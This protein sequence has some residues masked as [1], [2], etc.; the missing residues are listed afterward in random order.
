MVKP[1]I[2]LPQNDGKINYKWS[3]LEVK[4]SHG[5]GGVFA[6]KNIPRGTLIPILGS[7]TKKPPSAADNTDTHNWQYLNQPGIKGITIDGR[8]HINGHRGIG[9]FALGIAMMLNESDRPN[10]I[11]KYN[12][13]VVVRDVKAGEELT[14]YYGPAYE[15]IRRRHNYTINADKANKVPAAV[16]DW[17][18]PSAKER[19]GVIQH[20]LEE[21]QLRELAAES[22][23]CEVRVK[24]HCRRKKK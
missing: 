9:S 22:P 17:K 3:G 10:C 13:A 2:L 19:R 6:T 18:Y 8:P 21:I 4:Q 5:R 1:K 7:I 11:F 15:G 24:K 14:V 12:Y 16:W 23:K 20:Y